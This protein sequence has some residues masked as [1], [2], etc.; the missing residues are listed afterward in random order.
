[1]SFNPQTYLQKIYPHPRD[2]N[3]TFDEG[4]HIY[5]IKLENDSGETY[6][7]SGYT[8]VTTWNHS[9]FPHFDADKIL[10]INRSLNVDK[11]HGRDNVSVRMILMGDN[12]LVK[13]LLSIFN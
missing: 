2:D 9:H 6:Y 4:P 5:T 7:D 3:I 8:S 11:A 1:M 12:T 13:P 10:A